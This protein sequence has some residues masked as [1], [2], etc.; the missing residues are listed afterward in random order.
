VTGIHL[1]AVTP[2]GAAVPELFVGYRVCSFVF[3]LC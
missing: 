3:D 2:K 1:R